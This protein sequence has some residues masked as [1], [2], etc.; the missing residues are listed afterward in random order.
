MKKKYNKTIFAKDLQ[1]GVLFFFRWSLMLYMKSFT[2]RWNKNIFT[3]FLLK[4]PIRNFH[5]IYAFLNFGDKAILGKISFE[6]CKQLIHS[7]KINK[8]SKASSLCTTNKKK[9]GRGEWKN[10]ERYRWNNNLKCFWSIFV[11]KLILLFLQNKQ[12]EL[13]L[14]NRMLS[15]F[16][17]IQNL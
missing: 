4:K 17:R 6:K 5:I 2:I 15:S 1:N 9:P 10:Q 13:L 16:W 7:V 11:Q 14:M 8:L 12:I 3:F